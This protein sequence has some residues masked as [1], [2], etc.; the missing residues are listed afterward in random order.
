MPINGQKISKILHIH[1]HNGIVFS[2]KKKELLPFVLCGWP[3]S[4]MENCLWKGASHNC[5]IWGSRECNLLLLRVV[6]S[7]NSLCVGQTGSWE[8]KLGQ[9]ESMRVNWNWCFLQHCY[10]QCYR[11]WPSAEAAT[12]HHE[13]DSA[14]CLG[15]GRSWV[16]Q[17]SWR[18]SCE[19]SGAGAGSSQPR[20]TCNRQELVHT[21][22]MLGAFHLLHRV[23]VMS[24]LLYFLLQI[25]CKISLV[26]NA[27]QEPCS[28]ENS[29]KHGCRSALLW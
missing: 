13:V 23:K 4:T 18:A 21:V 17:E 20:G 5:G 9:L 1:T 10:P 2:C 3:L 27:D 8:G 15:P 19:S 12:I 6:L 7:H 11:D 22:M 24:L 25:G 14:L 28:G 16:R 26:A 29:E